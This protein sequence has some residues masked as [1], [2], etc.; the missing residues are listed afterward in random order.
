MA[1]PN[2]QPP[3]RSPLLSAFNNIVN[4][5]RSNYQIRSTKN[6]FDDFMRFMNVEVEG[7]KAQKL[8]DEKKI[9]KLSSLNMAS[10]FGRSGSL[11]SALASGAMDVAGFLGEFF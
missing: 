5:K 2:K 10:T 7:L 3:I 1:L 11:L 4:T 8:P 6:S 9:S